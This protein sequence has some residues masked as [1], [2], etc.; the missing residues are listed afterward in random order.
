MKAARYI[1]IEKRLK[2][3]NNVLTLGAKPNLDDYSPAEREML[4]N[5]EKIYYPTAFYADIFHTMG[6]PIFPSYH[7]YVYAQDKVKQTALFNLLDIPHPRTRT[8]YGNRKAS[9]IAHHFKFPFIG[10]IPRGSALGRGVFLITNEIELQRYCESTHVAYI[11]EYFP[12]KRDLRVVVI[13][14]DAVLA[15]WRVAPPFEYRT[16]VSIGG[17]VDFNA[18]PQPAVDLALETAKRCKWDDVGIDILQFESDF[19]VLEGNMKYGKAGFAAAGIDYFKMM[20]EK[21]ENGDI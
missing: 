2:N 8:F 9:R 12:I 1:A 15:Y 14:Y 13:G 10:K 17:R 19:F 4:R 5:A 18:I 20:E 6:K 21:I 7:S 16:N 3:C 11:Q